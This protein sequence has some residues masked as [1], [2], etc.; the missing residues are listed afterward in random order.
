[1]ADIQPSIGIQQKDCYRGALG[2]RKNAPQHQQEMR[3]AKTALLI[4][5]LIVLS[6]CKSR[7]PTNYYVSG[8]QVSRDGQLSPVGTR[9]L[10]ETRSGPNYFFFHAAE[11]TSIQHME[12]GPGESEPHRLLYLETTRDGRLDRTV[13]SDVLLMGD[14]GTIYADKTCF[15]NRPVQSSYN[16]V[17]VTFFSKGYT[18]AYD[19]PTVLPHAPEVVPPL[20]SVSLVRVIRNESDY[21]L[22][23]ADYEASGELRAFHVVRANGGDIYPATDES[24][25]PLNSKDPRLEKYGIPSI[26]KI[27]SDLTL[28]RLRLPSVHESEVSTWLIQFHGFGKLIHQLQLREGLPFSSRWLQPS[29]T[30]EEHTIGPEC[31][32]RFR[33]QLSMGLPTTGY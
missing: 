21:T 17:K 22:V 2:I 6:A 9:S 10:F 29:V 3:S 19:K 25:Y 32:S 5:V 20:S 4:T 15:Y 7:G 27:D 33:Q 14:F 23:S 18:E 11:L 24:S 12:R 26:L 30:K 16:S 31:D 28:H 13:K 1:V 8:I